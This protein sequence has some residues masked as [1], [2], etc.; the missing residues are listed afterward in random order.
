[1]IIN[2]NRISKI[3][4]SAAIMLLS[5]V[6]TLPARASDNR[7]IDVTFTKWITTFPL[8]AGVVGGPAGI[9]MFCISCAISDS[10]S[11]R[12]N[13]WNSPSPPRNGARPLRSLVVAPFFVG[14]SRAPRFVGD[15][16]FPWTP[17]HRAE[18]AEVLQIGDVVLLRYKLSDR[19]DPV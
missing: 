10:L 18:L 16:A 15:G 19:F 2:K 8:M 9:G 4:A 13:V 12:S 3:V 17:E 11:G 1:M 5:L 7:P 14:D 6:P